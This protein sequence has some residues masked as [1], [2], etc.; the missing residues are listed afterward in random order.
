MDQGATQ[1]NKINQKL[2]A[3]SLST[4]PSDGLPK[5]EGFMESIELAVPTAIV[6]IAHF[7]MPACAGQAY[8]LVT[9]A[10]ASSTQNVC[11]LITPS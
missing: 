11:C 10:V 8:W 2:S 9:N 1:R 7:T 4:N 6:A 3:Q 5:G